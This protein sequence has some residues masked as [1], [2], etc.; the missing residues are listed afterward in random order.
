MWKLNKGMNHK[1]SFIYLYKFYT[2]FAS[3]HLQETPIPSFWAP[4]QGD[5]YPLLSSTYLNESCNFFYS[6]Y[7]MQR[8][9]APLA[10]PFLPYF[11][12]IFNFFINF[13][14]LLLSIFSSLLQRQSFTTK[15]S[16]YI[17]FQEICN[18]SHHDSS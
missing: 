11:I 12:L 6:V 18:M 13:W 8:N 7:N 2:S 10:P 17:I 3:Y 16:D 15:C 4:T 5:T 1:Y 14:T 9:T